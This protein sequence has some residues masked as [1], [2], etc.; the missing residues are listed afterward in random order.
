[1]GSQASAHAGSGQKNFKKKNQQKK[2]KVEA[3][4]E[5]EA[6]DRAEADRT[7][8]LVSALTSGASPN[9]QPVMPPGA[10]PKAQHFM[11]PGASPKAQHI[12]PPGAS[13]KAMP[14]MPPGLSPPSGTKKQR[15]M[16]MQR[17]EGK[18]QR[19]IQNQLNVKKKIRHQEI[20]P[21]SEQ[22]RESHLQ[23]LA[24]SRVRFLMILLTD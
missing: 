22:A 13:P 24:H 19:R 2:K 21:M 7:N 14:V 6:E 3:E 11:P 15:Q 1:M 4:A 16:E 8:A 23:A 18:R 9:A 10:S 20:N 12:M 17:K 5:A